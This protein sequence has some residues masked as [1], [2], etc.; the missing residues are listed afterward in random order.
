MYN[1]EVFFIVCLYVWLLLLVSCISYD[2]VV[3]IKYT[4]CGGMDWLWFC[5][6]A[7]IHL[8]FMCCQHFNRRLRKAIAKRNKNAADRI[9]SNKPR[10]TLDKLVKERCVI[11]RGSSTG[12]AVTDWSMKFA[13]LTF[14]LKYYSNVHGTS[15]LILKKQQQKNI[16]QTSRCSCV[17]CC[18][19]FLCCYCTELGNDDNSDNIYNGNNK[20][21][22]IRQDNNS[23]N[24]GMISGALNNLIIY[25]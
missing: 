1:L 9:R 20:Y 7:V 19:H 10:Y 23:S 3:K 21:Y 12:A 14:L 15:F 16:L 2:I 24:N 13:K 8:L 22:F 17:C 18:C 6:E 11:C 4:C 5:G 25:F